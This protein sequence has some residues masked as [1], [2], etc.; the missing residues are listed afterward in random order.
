LGLDGANIWAHAGADMRAHVTTYQND[1]RH[2]PMPVYFLSFPSAKDPAWG[3]RYPGRTTIDIGG[4]TSWSLFEPFADSRWMRRGEHYEQLKKVLAEELL[5]QVMRFCPQLHGKIDHAELASP[6]S[7]N[8]FL[9]RASGDFMSYAHTPDRF[10][11]RWISAHSPVP[12]LYFS[13]QDV[14]A[15]G[16]SGAMIGGATAASAV[17]GRN[18]LE[19]LPAATHTPKSRTHH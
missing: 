15:A 18:I 2:K 10:Q 17:L 13:G 8:H 12:G 19:N 16:V 4:L 5:D 6:L 9:A 1:P 14:V 3:R 11:Q 7:F